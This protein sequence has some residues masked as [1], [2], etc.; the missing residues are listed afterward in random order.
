MIAARARRAIPIAAGLAGLALSG[1]GEGSGSPGLP[2]KAAEPAESPPLSATPAGTVYPAGRDPE[3][4]AA[5]PV[6][7]LVAVGSRDPDRLLLLDRSS[8][9]IVRRV[10]LPAAPRHLSLARPGGPVLVPAESADSLIVVDLPS[11]KLR[12]VA[13]GRHPHDATFAAGKAFVSDEYGKAVSVVP[14][15]QGPASTMRAPLQPGGIT[16]LDGYVAL[17]AVR[18]RVLQTYDARSLRPIARR[19]AGVGPTHAVAAAGRIYVADTQGDALR[20]FGL[21]QGRPVPAGRVAAPGSPYGIALDRRRMRLWLTLTARDRVLEFDLR[22]G[23][24]VRIAAYPT[25]RQPNSIAV[26]SSTGDAFVAG[27]SAGVVERIAGGSKP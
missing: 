21:R 27:R 8:G 16:S 9:K 5:D 13:V 2:P 20:V 18:A 10:D 12:S 24:P 3:G 6:T 15:L 23:R 4:I 7:G 19:P 17:V 22:S 11:G 14:G 26:D 25:V 1:C